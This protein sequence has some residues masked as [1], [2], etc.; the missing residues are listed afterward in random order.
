[1][2][3]ALKKIAG[4]ES[5]TEGQIEII[6]CLPGSPN[7]MVCLSR[8]ATVKNLRDAA[9]EELGVEPDASFRFLGLPHQADVPLV[10]LGMENGSTVDMI[11]HPALLRL[12]K[13]RLR[14][15][16]ESPFEKIALALHYCCI[17]AGF[18]CKTKVDTSQQTDLLG[19]APAVRKRD[20]SNVDSVPVGWNSTPGV[21]WWELE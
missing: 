7:M 10:D 16:Y 8:N 18:V 3:E 12:E 11:I 15:P 6:L 4:D 17:E 19:F 2:E 21:A 5:R 1:M 14:H 20:L 9:A 13:A